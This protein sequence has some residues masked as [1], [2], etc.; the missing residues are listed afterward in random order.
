MP[1][2]TVG[3]LGGGDVLGA[4]GSRGVVEGAGR[5][6]GRVPLDRSGGRG[7]PVRCEVV[8]GRAQVGEPAAKRGVGNAVPGD[9]LELVG[10]PSPRPASLPVAD[11]G[12]LEAVGEAVVQEL[13]ERASGSWVHHGGPVNICQPLIHEMGPCA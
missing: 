10:D 11:D 1:S 5:R 9:P 2:S 4:S 3:A 6:D 12:R 13:V 8:G 7:R